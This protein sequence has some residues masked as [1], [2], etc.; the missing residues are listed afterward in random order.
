[1]EEKKVCDTL[2]CSSYDEYIKSIESYQKQIN[3]L[4]VN[5]TDKIKKL[6]IENK[7]VKCNKQLDKETITKIILHNKELILKAR[8]V[9]AENKE[10][11]SKVIKE[12]K[13]FI[14]ANYPMF[15][16]EIVA[17]GK[18]EKAAL[19]EKF[20]I[21]RTEAVQKYVDLE[22]SAKA[23][24]LE[25]DSK[26]NSALLKVKK[27]RK[28]AIDE[29]NKVKSDGIAKIKTEQHNLFMDK[30]NAFAAAHDGSLP[31]LDQIVGKAEA[32]VYKFNLSSFL[33]KNGLYIIIIIFMIACIIM[34]PS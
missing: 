34:E 4:R 1:M 19:L 24:M 16:A 13:M 8:E 28:L 9:A 6:T 17:K 18:E 20:K 31:I 27:E 32:Y 23:D 12:Q 33:M 29:I 3:A 5:G 14:N 11:I 15:K 7:S 21:D 22:A 10:E 25:A 30:Q 26:D 2:L